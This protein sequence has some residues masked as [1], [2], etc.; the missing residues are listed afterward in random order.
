MNNLNQCI[1]FE[2]SIQSKEGYIVSLSRSP[3][4]IH[5][6]FHDFI[7]NLEHVL[8]ESTAKNRLFVVICA[9]NFT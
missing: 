4:E 6:E 8:C 1:I 5:D 9:G 2:V 7:L 3:S